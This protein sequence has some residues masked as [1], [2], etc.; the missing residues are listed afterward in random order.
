MVTK[1]SQNSLR[2]IINSESIYDLII[3]FYYFS[4]LTEKI[5]IKMSKNVQKS[6]KKNLV[7][8]KFFENW[9]FLK[10]PKMKKLSQSCEK[11]FCD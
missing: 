11:N 8:K 6:C 3:L 2:K 10:C 4:F 1:N 5:Q 7:Q 9:T